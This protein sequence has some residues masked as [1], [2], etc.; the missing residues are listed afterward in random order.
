MM[1]LKPDKKLRDALFVPDAMAHPAKG[2]IG[3]WW[4]I[5]ERYTEPDEWI[6][7]PMAGIGTTL[8]AC[9]MGRNVWANEMETHF[10]EPMQAS[11]VKMQQHGP[12]LGHSLG[13][14]QIV[15]GDARALLTPAYALDAVVT[16]PPYEAAVSGGGGIALEGDGL[17]TK[18]GLG[19]ANRR[20]RDGQYQG[21]ALKG[22]GLN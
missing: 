12:M 11:W 7:D 5:I 4:E 10:L 3:L 22:L 1:R 2:H 13:Q 17:I 6:L 9:L 20:W 15:Q 14:A 19:E 8:I 21:D 18:G 16:S